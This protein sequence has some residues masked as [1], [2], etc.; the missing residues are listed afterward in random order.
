[1][2]VRT[3]RCVGYLNKREKRVRCREMF[4]VYSSNHVRCKACALIH[5]KFRERRRIYGGARPTAAAGIS[6]PDPE[7]FREH[8]HALAVSVMAGKRLL[9]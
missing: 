7:T 3:R 2:A 4:T 6:G 5:E 9:A 8:C 1:M